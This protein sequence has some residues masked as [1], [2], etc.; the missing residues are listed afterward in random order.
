MA[1]ME[2]RTSGLV[3]D[4]NVIHVAGLFVAALRDASGEP[5]KAGTQRGRRYAKRASSTEGSRTCQTARPGSVGVQA[6][7]RMT[8]SAEEPSFAP[9]GGGDDRSDGLRATRR[10]KGGLWLSLPNRREGDGG[11]G[12]LADKYAP[13]TFTGEL[14]VRV[15]GRCEGALNSV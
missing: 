15:A 14:Y 7:R 9:R 13:N 2:Q 3:R 12:R 10:E 5:W 11:K 4:R 1:G 6:G 8:A